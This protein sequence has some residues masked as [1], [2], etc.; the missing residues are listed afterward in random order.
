MSDGDVTRSSAFTGGEAGAWTGPVT[1]VDDLTETLQSLDPL[2]L[3][4]L[5]L[6]A[7][8]LVLGSGGSFA[9]FAD[10]PV[11]TFDASSQTTTR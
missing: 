10:Q 11:Y 3:S 2:V 4:L 5:V 7:V 1:A 9:G 6:G 8:G